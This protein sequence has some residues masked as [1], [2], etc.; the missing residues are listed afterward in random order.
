MLSTAFEM[1]I[2]EISVITGKTEFEIEVIL[3]AKK[4]RKE[5]RKTNEIKT[6][7]NSIVNPKQI[8]SLRKPALGTYERTNLEGE[9]LRI[10]TE[11]DIEEDLKTKLF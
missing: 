4:I 2:C 8:K 1:G 10:L 5:V 9:P 6:D 7:L 3:N 11:D